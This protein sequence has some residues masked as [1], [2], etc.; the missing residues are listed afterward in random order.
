MGLRNVPA[1]MQIGLKR[2]DYH[3]AV[4]L[5]GSSSGLWRWEIHCAGRSGPVEK[6][7]TYFESMSAATKA[8][9]EALTLLLDR[10]Y[11]HPSS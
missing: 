1:R 10:F 9:K 4:K 11:P 8:G 3:L 6:S 7:P 2:S 5:N